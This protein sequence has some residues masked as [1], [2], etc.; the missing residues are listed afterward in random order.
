MKLKQPTR[1]TLVDQVAAQIDAL[2]QSGQWP[3]GTR[4]PPEPQLVEQLGVSRNTLREAVRALVH[5]GL[6]EARQ[7]DGTYVCSA[8]D[9]G[10]A[11]HRRLRRSDIAETLEVRFALEQEAARLAAKRR[12]E[13]DI[14]VF[15]RHL[16]DCNS[17]KTLDDYIQA[18]MRL[19]LAI[20]AA[21]R[22]SVLIDL[23]AH[24]TDAI[25]MS[26]GGT[27][28]E[29]VVSQSFAR[30]D[31]H[32]K[33]HTELVE[34]IVAQDPALAQEAVRTLIQMSQNVL[35]QQENEEKP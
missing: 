26:I 12:T 29:L 20:V 23:Y 27:V 32:K 21:T 14:E 8:S 30:F 1:L 35:Q 19:H 11:L 17:A 15:R 34:A 31:D 7:G 33:M 3:V 16:A 2:I 28:D 10:A 13:A 24:M 5:A 18:D 6:L 9:L 4:I 25:R 22:N